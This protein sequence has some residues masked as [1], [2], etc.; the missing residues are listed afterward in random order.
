[1]M[2]SRELN[3]IFNSSEIKDMIKGGSSQTFRGGGLRFEIVK[4][5]VGAKGVNQDGGGLQAPFA[6]PR[7][8]P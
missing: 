8:R 7:I 1:M 2:I 6:P 4:D 3:F 5:F